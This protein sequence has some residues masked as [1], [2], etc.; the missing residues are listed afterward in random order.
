M[1]HKHIFSLAVKLILASAIFTISVNLIGKAQASQYDKLINFKRDYDWINHTNFESDRQLRLQVFANHSVIFQQ[2]QQFYSPTK[3]PEKFRI[4]SQLPIDRPDDT[5]SPSLRRSPTQGEPE[6]EPQR[7][8]LRLPPR[9]FYRSSP[10]VTI[11][12]PSGYGAGWGS[13]GIGI[14][15]QERVRFIDESDGVIGLG[16]GLGN[17]QKNIGLQI[18]ITLVDLSDIFRDG[19]VNLKLHRRFSNDLSVAVGIQGFS[20]FGDTDGGSSGYAGFTRRFALKDNV[21]RPL[22]ELYISLGI[23]GGQF[24]TESDINNGVESLGVFGSV[25]VRIIEPLNFITEWTGQ[26][27]TIGV[28]F[29][30]FRNLPLVVIPAITDITGTAGDG[31]RFIFG[32][33][34]SFSF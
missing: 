29:V 19:T 21:T 2:H 23:G 22:S 10:G 16:F 30:P 15:I 12:T 33:G 28:S 9:R 17:P 1:S 8:P 6:F 13:A 26:D 25:A 11:I 3:T 34:Y 4:L 20:T 32:V 14:G 18:G 24:R 31:A 7:I 5:G 27:L